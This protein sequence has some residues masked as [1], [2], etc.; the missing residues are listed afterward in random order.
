MK[1]RILYLALYLVCTLAYTLLFE[2]SVVRWPN[3][4]VSVVG[5]IAAFIF[6]GKFVRKRAKPNA[7]NIFRRTLNVIHALYLI[8]IAVN[9]FKGWY[10]N[11][12]LG[13]V[14]IAPMSALLIELYFPTN[15][16]ACTPP[17]QNDA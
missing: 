13:I 15:T 4:F 11:A 16:N 3:V 6:I 14:F 9:L 17:V 12:L 10:A 7:V 1:I 5:V 2:T 8:L